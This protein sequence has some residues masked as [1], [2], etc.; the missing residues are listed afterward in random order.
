MPGV[1]P[2]E[3]SG[4]TLKHENYRHPKLFSHLRNESHWAGQVRHPIPILLPIP[5]QCG[6]I[7][8]ASLAPPDHGLTPTAASAHLRPVEI[9]DVGPSVV[10]NPAVARLVDARRL[11]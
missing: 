9:E 8:I 10:G 7:G 11:R 6:A 4:L 2:S 5:P 1:F 3:H